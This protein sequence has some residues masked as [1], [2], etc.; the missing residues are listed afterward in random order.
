MLPTGKRA[1]TAEDAVDEEGDAEVAGQNHDAAS[2]EAQGDGDEQSTGE[3]GEEEGDEEESESDSDDSDA[4]EMVL[5]E[6][7]RIPGGMPGAPTFPD[8]NYEL[9]SYPKFLDF[10]D[11]V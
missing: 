10:G 9:R 2:E 1:R 7:G 8:L 6:F 4:D 3:E 11:K 5:D